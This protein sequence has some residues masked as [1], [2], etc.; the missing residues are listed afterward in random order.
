MDVNGYPTQ[1]S[2]KRLRTANGYV[3]IDRATPTAVGQTLVTTAEVA[4]GLWESEWGTGGGPAGPA[5][6]LATTDAPVNVGS[7]APPTAGEVLTA[8]SATAAEWLPIPP[9]SALATNTVNPVSVVSNPPVVG[10][11]LTADSATTASWKPLSVSLGIYGSTGLVSG[12]LLTQNTSTTFNIALGKGFIAT[13]PSTVEVN[14]TAKTAVLPLDPV[15]KPFT[16]VFI[17]SAGNVYRTN[18][19]NSDI[20][21]RAYIQLGVIYHPNADNII[22]SILNIPAPLQQP[23]NSLVDF[24]SAIGAFNITGNTYSGQAG[25][26]LQ[27]KKT[28]GSIWRFGANF[29]TVP[30]GE[31]E[32]HRVAQVAIT[33]PITFTYARRTQG[34]MATAITPALYNPTANTT[35]AVSN[36]KWTVQRIY[37]G[38]NNDTSVQYGQTEYATMADAESGIG[39]D[40][41]ETIFTGAATV[42]RYYLVLK[43]ECTSLNDTTTCKFIEAGRFGSVPGGSSSTPSGNTGFNNAIAAWS[44]ATGHWSGALVATNTLSWLYS[45]STAPYRIRVNTQIRNNSGSGTAG[46]VELLYVNNTYL[47]TASSNNSNLVYGSVSGGV[48]GDTNFRGNP[49]NTLGGYVMVNS[50]NTGFTMYTTVPN[51][52]GTLI[53]NNNPLM[54]N[55][56]FEYET[57]VAPV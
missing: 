50:T 41:F 37:L 33:T 56:I 24:A 14:W 16:V 20:T 43:K 52:S 39:V 18:G 40:P 4:P 3:Q 38:P 6:E 10:T 25:T 55:V 11:V 34:S 21:R 46:S 29:H 17:D 19:E 48:S 12:G 47:P 9:A 45:K 26:S 49:L 13:G 35:T 7:S 23:L 57:N 44:G 8:T 54:G 28:A 36:N 53:P 30:N 1:G 5:E 51:A 2:A 32:P 22:I 15:N 31:N 42:L 27:L